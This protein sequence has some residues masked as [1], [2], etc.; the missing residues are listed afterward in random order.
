MN[1]I[2]HEESVFSPC[3]EYVEQPTSNVVDAESVLNCFN[4]RLDSHWNGDSV[5]EY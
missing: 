1:L 5:Y 3:N 4:S 2:I